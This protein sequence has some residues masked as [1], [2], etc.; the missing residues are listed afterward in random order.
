MKKITVSCKAIYSVLIV[1]LLGST[2]ADAAAVP[3][4]DIGRAIGAGN[5]PKSVPIG[6]TAG[7]AARLNSSVQSAADSD[8]YYRMQLLME[9]LRQLRGLIEEQSNELALIKK[10]QA[11]DYLDLDGRLSAFKQMG[12]TQT[13]I[14]P[15][16]STVTG[17]T[18]STLDSPDLPETDKF[19]GAADRPSARAKSGPVAVLEQGGEKAAYN[20]AYDLLK[21]RKVIAAKTSLKQFLVEYPQGAYTANAHYWL[22]EVYLLDGQLSEAVTEFQAVV[23]Q[24]PGHRK[25]NDASFKLGKVYHLQNELDKSRQL[26]ERVAEGSDSA[27]RLAQDYL[28]RNF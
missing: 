14:L 4:E 5:A 24:Y 19:D 27:A 12:V 26:L 28:L 11:E 17:A 15:G 6:N 10:R 22:G 21:D 7:T 8:P 23:S 9:E 3:V 25:V 1:T 20:R 2:L 13:G 18:G 16:T